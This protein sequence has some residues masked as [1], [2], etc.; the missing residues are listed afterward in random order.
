MAGTLPQPNGVSMQD[1]PAI[2]DIRPLLQRL[3][4]DPTAAQVTAKEIAD[5]I[6]LIFTNNLSPVQIGSLLTALHFT[7]WDRRAD[8]LAE[9]SAAMRNASAPIDFKILNEV[10]QRKAR[11]EGR[12]HGGLVSLRK[13]G[14]KANIRL[15]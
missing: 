4:P 12:Y 9:T 10:V 5:A 6:A 11:R 8:V 14:E 13:T 15:T 1:Q 2:V 3:W 7:G